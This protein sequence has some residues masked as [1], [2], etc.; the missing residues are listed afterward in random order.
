MTKKI[1]KLLIP[2]SVFLLVGVGFLLLRQPEV[3]SAP[4]DNVTGYAWSSTIGWVSFNCDNNGSCGSSNYGVGIDPD[5]GDMTGYAWSSNIGWIDFA[6]SAPYPDSPDHSAKLDLDSREI[7]GWARAVN[8]TGEDYGWIKFNYGEDGSYLD[9]TAEFQGWAWGG[10]P[11]EKAVIGWLSLNCENTA[12]CDDSDY[13]VRVK[14]APPY[15]TSTDVGE[16]TDQDFCLSSQGGSTANYKLSWKFKDDEDII[17]DYMR[18]FKIKFTNIASSESGTYTSVTYDSDAYPDGNV[19]FSNIQASTKE[20]LDEK[21]IK[22]K[23]NQNYSWEVRVQDSSYEQAWSDWKSG[24]DINLPQKYPLATFDYSP[25]EPTVNEEVSFDGSA[26]EAYGAGNSITN[27]FWDMNIDDSESKTDTGV[28]ATNTY[29][30]IGEKE[31]QLDVTDDIDTGRT[32]S[33]TRTI[34]VEPQPE[35]WEEVVPR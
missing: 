14:N 18:K 35:K 30:S 32:C 17:D 29:Q 23:Y 28:T 8:S 25:K 1:F 12:S 10:G 11:K 13:A 34:S 27:Y 20:G 22:L 4:E 2:I 19:K 24:P 21:P 33:T 5:S 6:P 3:R 15:A 7:T 26:S 16:P 31:V 9:S